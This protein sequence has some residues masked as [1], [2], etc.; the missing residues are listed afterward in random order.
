MTSYYWFAF[1]P[2]NRIKQ[3]IDVTHDDLVTV[4]HELGHIQYIVQYWDLPFEYRRGAN[5]GFHEAVGDTLSLSVD[6]PQHLKMVGLLS[7]YDP[8]Q[9]ELFGAWGRPVHIQ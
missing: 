9:G 7:S 2:I 6:T 4:H 1:F 5:P 3:C 8:D